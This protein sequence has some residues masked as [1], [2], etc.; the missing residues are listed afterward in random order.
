MQS[1]VSSWSFL[2]GVAGLFF[3]AGILKKKRAGESCDDETPEV[4]KRE[5]IK[6]IFSSQT[7]TAESFA[8]EISEEAESLGLNVRLLDLADWDE[9]TESEKAF[10][11]SDLTGFVLF[12][13]A[14]YGEGDAPDSG[15]DFDRW[16]S[17]RKSRPPSA[18]V[19][20]KG[21]VDLRD[22]KYSVCALGSSE[23]K[24]F[25]AFG[26][27]IDFELNRLGAS[28][29]VNT[30]LCDDA[31]DAEGE[32]LTW[33][34]LVLPAIIPD[35]EK[36][37]AQSAERTRPGADIGMVF[38]KR[39]IDLPFDATVLNGGGDI[40]SKFYFSSHAVPVS[41][42]KKLSSERLVVLVELDISRL[43]AVRYRTAD[44]L[45]MIPSNSD[46]SVTW[47][48]EKFRVI[49]KLDDWLTFSKLTSKGSIK[50]LFPTPCTLRRALQLYCDLNGMPTRAFIKEIAFLCGRSKEEADLISEKTHHQS[51]I[52]TMR[53]LIEQHFIDIANFVSIDRFLVLCPKLKP[54]S[55]TISSSSI[56]Q[57]KTIGLTV[58]L[59]SQ[60]D[61]KGVTSGYL[62]ERLRPGDVIQH[63][64][65]KP[66]LF[67]L[68]SKSELPVIMIAAGTGIAPF[69]GFIRDMR[70]RNRSGPKMLF[71]GC[72][73]SSD[74][75]YKE[76][77]IQFQS[78]GG[79][80]F[81]AT[82]REGDKHYVQDLVKI[83]RARF[84][85]LM[86]MGAVIYVCGSTQMCRGLQQVLNTF[87]P[88]ESIK[89]QKRYIEEAWG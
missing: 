47:M 86:G 81:V 52:V 9:S 58:V 35:Y 74:W 53:S 55:Y 30:A 57:P 24:E 62:C 56:E 61:F 69:R 2:A 18:R 16:L 45:E 70:V 66:S 8:K 83:Q 4:A 3:L 68:P 32:F 25:C 27:R 72:R 87:I 7:G 31:L 1:S 82:S 13:V 15:T 48:A 43:P 23:Y 89:A 85:L 12:V 37:A 80:L 20:Q 21:Y 36:I 78:D 75:I 46:E 39:K 11:P 60:D 50:K 65:V 64:N 14:T 84:E 38:A 44:T 28:R 76:E 17:E 67:R 63:M 77:M 5:T 26:K 34:S 49:D 22:L 19:P 41:A 29:L 79:E 33:K 6:I 42:V 88:L 51:V 10:T 73:S 59:E 71:F 54:R 40:I